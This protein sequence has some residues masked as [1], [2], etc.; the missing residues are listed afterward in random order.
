MNISALHAK[1]FTLF[2]PVLHAT[3]DPAPVLLHH[4]HKIGYDSCYTWHCHYKGNA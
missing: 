1:H 4:S 3:I 2:M